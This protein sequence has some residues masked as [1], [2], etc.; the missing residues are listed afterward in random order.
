MSR[1]PGSL[2]APAL[3]LDTDD[4]VVAE[5]L[6]FLLSIDRLKQVRR[7]NPLI[8]GQR[9]ERTAEH[10]WHLAVAVM[11]LHEH[12][13]EDIDVGRAV[14]LAIIHDLPEAVVGDTFV[15]GPLVDGRRE[16]EERALQ[17][18]L[19]NASGGTGSA[20][21][22]AWREYEDGTTPE[23]RYVKALDVLLP[24]FIN[25]A[26]G[27]DSSW[28]RYGIAPDAVRSRVAQIEAAVPSLAALALKVIGRAVT[29]GLLRD[30][31]P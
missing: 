25:Y 8:D 28:A 6:E 31:E 4:A 20:I 27:P 30:G 21:I 14:Q 2:P 3:D 24:I 29:Q 5:Q 11:C 17:A 16:R 13:S 10:C 26:S 12:A 15:Y 7:R 19:A 22:E 23:G 18:L 1:Q 9:R